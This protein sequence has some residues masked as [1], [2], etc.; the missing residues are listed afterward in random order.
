MCIIKQLKPNYI[1]LKINKKKREEEHNQ[2]FQIQN[3]PKLIFLYCKKQNL[4]QQLYHS[5]LKCE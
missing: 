4:N 1:N 3:K 5:H 2:R